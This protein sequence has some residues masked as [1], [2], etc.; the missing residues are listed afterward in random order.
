MTSPASSAAADT[1]LGGLPAAE[2]VLHASH[3]LELVIVEIRYA[4]ATGTF[5]SDDA[6]ALR[7]ALQ[8]VDVVVPA[9]EAVANQ[10]VSFEVGPQGPNANISTREL[11]WQLAAPDGGISAVVTSEAIRVQTTRYTRWS[12]SLATPLEVIFAAAQSVL[13]PQLVQRIG[14]RFIN[15]FVDPDARS[16]RSWVGRIE[17]PF[18]GPIADELLGARLQSTQQ[19]LDITLGPAQ[20]AIVRHGAFIDAAERGAVSYLLDIDIYNQTGLKAEPTTIMEEAT[21]LDRT[22]LTLFQQ[23]TTPDLRAQMRPYQRGE[24]APTREAVAP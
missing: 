14:V 16:P 3:S 17:T 18:L 5:T 6:L 24:G 1:P 4:G 19:Q 9:I 11:G 10:E 12:E 2:P 8:A 15:R 22:A 23:I 13:M 7:D 21:R 20:G